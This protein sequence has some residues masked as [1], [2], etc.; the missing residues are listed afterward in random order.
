MENGHEIDQKC[1]FQGLSKQVGKT[2][3]WQPCQKLAEQTT[4][5]GLVGSR[6]GRNHF[7]RSRVSAADVAHDGHQLR[8][9]V[10]KTR[11]GSD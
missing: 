8:R 5:S 6:D 9:M 4:R 1:P 2:A 10:R 11:A 3:I 7:P